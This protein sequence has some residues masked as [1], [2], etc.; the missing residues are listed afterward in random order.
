MSCNARTP[1][2]VAHRS[3]GATAGTEVPTDPFS[4]AAR[5]SL[6]HQH[7]D[8][9]YRRVT[10]TNDN[11]DKMPRP[12]NSTKAHRPVLANRLVHCNPIETLRVS[13]S[14]AEKPR[15]RIADHV[16]PLVD[17]R[18]ARPVAARAGDRNRR[19]IGGVWR[20]ARHHRIGRVCRICNRTPD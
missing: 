1:L 3:P 7:C 15:P 2:A 10:V 8:E 4:G 12:N 18:T 6:M 17:Q 9:L 13:P 20:I 16:T 5:S 14:G 11:A 19:R